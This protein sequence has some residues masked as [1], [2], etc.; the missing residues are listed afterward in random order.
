MRL[1]RAW[2]MTRIRK[3]GRGITRIR[4]EMRRM[5]KMKKMGGMREMS[6][7]RKTKLRMSRIK[8]G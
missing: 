3:M 5:R 8:L 6:K 2:R 1:N 4:K 7:M